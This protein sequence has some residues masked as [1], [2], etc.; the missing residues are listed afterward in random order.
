M[1]LRVRAPTDLLERARAVS[2]RLPGQHRRAYRDYQGRM[3]TDAV[4]TAIAV[5]EPFTDAFLTGLLPLLRHGAALGLWRL[6][7]AETS[8]GPEKAWLVGAEAVRV[9]HWLSDAPVSPADQ[10]L[11]RVAEALERD[12]A[13]HAS[14]RFQTAAALARRYLTGPGAKDWEETLYEQ[15]EAWD[16]EYQDRL[17]ADDT[18]E[19]RFRRRHGTTSYDWT[20]RGGTAAWRAERRVDLGYFEEWLVERTKSD[21]AAGVMQEPASPGWLLRTPPTWLAHAPALTASGQPP[22]PYATWAAECRM[23]AFPYRRKQAFWPLLCQPGTPRWQPVPGFEPAAASAAGLRPAQVLGFIEALLIDWNHTFT[24]EPSLRIALDLPADQARRFG[25]IT[26]DEQHRIMAE[27][28]TTT[29]KNM[30]G[31][32]AWAADDGASELYLQKLQEARGDSHAFHRLTLKYTDRKRPKF[33]VARA[34]W[35]WPGRSVAAE[36]VAGS[37]PGLVQ[38]LATEAHRRSCLLLEQAMEAAW[39]HAFDQYGFRM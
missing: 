27:A 9:D 6:A 5:A 24:E 3:L 38:W 8:T 1:P 20:G 13:W 21:P 15:D 23:L 11:L 29:L 28:R 32:I 19:R 14:K 12:E 31:F 34:T 22:E 7:V 2:L 26:A 25:F 33:G 4:T 36:L 17:Q 16:L 35:T 18:E 39:H 10:H 30:D 37:P